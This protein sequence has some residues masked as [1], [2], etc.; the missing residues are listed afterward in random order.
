MRTRVLIAMAALPMAVVALAAQ[1]PATA[2]VLKDA[3]RDRE[4]P[5]HVH[6]PADGNACVAKSACPVVFVS[7][8]YGIAPTDY[9][10][11]ATALARQGHLVVAIQH[12]LP[13]DPPLLGKGDLVTVRTP[14]WQRGAANLRFVQSELSRTLP[15]YD[16]SNLTLV[17]HSNGGDISSLLLRETP[18]F[19]TRLITL[20]HRRVPLPLDPSLPV[21]SIRA[22]DF[23][24]DPGVLPS[25]DQKEAAS[26]CVVEIA[27]ARHNDMFDGGPPALKAEINA[28][29]RVFV[30]AGQCGR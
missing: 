17:G 4:V 1:P 3:A 8:G 2:L 12:D 18:G 21:L 16:W 5:V 6:L 24:A 30:T 28:L 15:G 20:D 10:F 23:E 26:V 7:P 11:I 9:S 27:G 25:P 19:A 22:S 13:S 29:I 14:A